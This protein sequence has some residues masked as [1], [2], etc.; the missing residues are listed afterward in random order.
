MNF[1]LPF[2][3]YLAQNWFYDINFNNWPFEWWKDFVAKKKDN[4]WNVIQYLFQL[5]TDAISREEDAKDTIFQLEQATTEEHFPIK[6]STE[7]PLVLVLVTIADYKTKKIGKWPQLL[8]SFE[9]KIQKLNPKMSFVHWNHVDLLTWKTDELTEYTIDNYEQLNDYLY[10]FIRT[11]KSSVINIVE[12]INGLDFS[13]IQT[14]LFPGLI[15]FDWLLENDQTLEWIYLLI[16]TLINWIVL[17]C[18]WTE[19]LFNYIIKQLL[20]LNKSM[21][22]WFNELV[23]SCGSLVWYSWNCTFLLEILSIIWLIDLKIFQWS[24]QNEIEKMLSEVLNNK[25]STKFISDNYAI[26]LESYLYFSTLKNWE[27]DQEFLK[28]LYLRFLDR[29][30]TNKLWVWFLE[31]WTSYIEEVESFMT[32]QKNSWDEILTS[33]IWYVIFKWLYFTKQELREIFINDLNAPQIKIASLYAFEL[34]SWDRISPNINSI[35]TWW[36]Y[37]K[38]VEEVNLE[39]FL[40]FYLQRKVIYKE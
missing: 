12:I 21:E 10:R 5:K 14:S 19:D 4:E 2:K 38:D 6:C 40:K 32:N 23:D 29:H 8:K 39:D 30:D 1:F 34:D 17:K 18:D 26:W 11:W 13:R 36:K 9:K 7:L 25:W 37:I 33:L 24:Y 28:N 15:L 31:L 35:T 27:P 3:Y 20:D 22:N 16:I